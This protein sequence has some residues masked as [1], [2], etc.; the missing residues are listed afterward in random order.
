MIRTLNIM[1]LLI[2]FVLAAALYVAKNDVKHAQSRLS[3]LQTKITD[4]REA[5]Q[6]LENEEAFLENPDRLARLAEAHLGAV[7]LRNA[8]EMT[9]EQALI[10]LQ[11]EIEAASTLASLSEPPLLEPAR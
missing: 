7:P 6:L 3:A 11:D 5:V 8:A 9:P 10:E 4:T 2:A 1:A